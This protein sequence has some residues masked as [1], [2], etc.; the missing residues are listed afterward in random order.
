MSIA[1]HIKFL[2]IIYSNYSKFLVII[3]FLLSQDMINL[4]CFMLRVN[5][6]ERPYI[7]SVIEE[8]QKMQSQLEDR[9]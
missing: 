1:E 8:A 4:I 3:L 6:M 9:I 5:A 7:Y 2:L